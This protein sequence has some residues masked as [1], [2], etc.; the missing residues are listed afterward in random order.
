MLTI[1][2]GLN[3][4]FN[5]CRKQMEGY[6]RAFAKCKQVYKCRG[7]FCDAAMFGD[8]DKSIQLE[9]ASMVFPEWQWPR[10]GALDSDITND[11]M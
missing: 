8:F 9:D 7:N 5:D 3:K 10:L 4:S 1:V 2:L 11:C 6:R